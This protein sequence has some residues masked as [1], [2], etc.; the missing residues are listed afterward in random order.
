MAIHV[1]HKVSLYFS[2]PAVN[3]RVEELYH[4]Y[5]HQQNGLSVEEKV[6]VIR[7]IENGEKR[8]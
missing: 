7:K 1:V 8:S 6:T 4:G 3:R 5:S 2:T